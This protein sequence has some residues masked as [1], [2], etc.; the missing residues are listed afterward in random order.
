MNNIPLDNLRQARR[1]RL[2]HPGRE[3]QR[4]QGTRRSP[5]CSWPP[6]TSTAE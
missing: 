4:R 3:R 6:A 1:R 5:A 2:Q